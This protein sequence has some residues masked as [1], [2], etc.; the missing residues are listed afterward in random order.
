MSA[1]RIC[2][3][4]IQFHRVLGFASLSLS[5]VKLNFLTFYLISASVCSRVIMFW[6]PFDYCHK[7]ISCDYEATS[8]MARDFIFKSIVCQSK[9]PGKKLLLDACTLD[10]GDLQIFEEEEKNILKFNPSILCLPCLRYYLG[11]V[12]S[13][14]TSGTIWV[15]SST[16][17]MILFT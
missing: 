4:I 11:K 16:S 7:I 5:S 6:M 13:P 3:H 1:M 14:M 17:C 10:R 2:A 8:F 15:S 9:L 12:G